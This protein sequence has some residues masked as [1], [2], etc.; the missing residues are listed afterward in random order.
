MTSL[1]GDSELSESSSNNLEKWNNFVGFAEI[2]YENLI[3]NFSESAIKNPIAANNLA[4]Q[5]L[6]NAMQKSRNRSKTNFRQPMET[7]HASRQLG[8]TGPRK[9]RYRLRR[10]DDI[11]IKGDTFIIRIKGL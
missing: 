5:S 7:R 3:D 6:R 4:N 2:A 10:G 8:S 11:G 9:K 1:S